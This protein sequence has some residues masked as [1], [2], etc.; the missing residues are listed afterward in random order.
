MIGE[1]EGRRG[2][3]DEKR[4]N[5]KHGLEPCVYCPHVEGHVI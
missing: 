4:L 1:E 3:M 5:G 2:W